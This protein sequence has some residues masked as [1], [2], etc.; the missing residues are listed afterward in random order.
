MIYSFIIAYHPD[1]FEPYI[2]D[3]GDC[4]R[5]LLRTR[6]SHH[7]VYPFLQ[8]AFD[9]GM[10][11]YT[12]SVADGLRRAYIAKEIDMS[13]ENV[14]KTWYFNYV[15]NFW[16]QKRDVCRVLLNEYYEI[17]KEREDVA[18]HV[19]SCIDFLKNM[20]GYMGEQ[21]LIDKFE[22]IYK[23]PSSMILQ[24]YSLYYEIVNSILLFLVN[25]RK[26]LLLF[27]SLYL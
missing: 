14:H 20:I 10:H 23:N 19:R 5:N 6:G 25:E 24:E 21:E 22:S 11:N 8:K 9:K 16:L 4:L 1:L 12:S 17:A 7:L 15:A 27:C 18:N 2:G 26:D 3:Y 13:A